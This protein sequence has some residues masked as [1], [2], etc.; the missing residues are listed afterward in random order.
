MF[1]HPVS[2][3]GGKVEETANGMSLELKGEDR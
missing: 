1:E 3:P 2:H